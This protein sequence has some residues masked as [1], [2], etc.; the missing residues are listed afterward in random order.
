MGEDLS[1]KEIEKR[2]N[3]CTIIKGNFIFVDNDYDIKLYDENIICNPSNSIFSHVEKN[4]S[5]FQKENELDKLYFSYIISPSHNIFKFNLV[6][7]WGTDE[8]DYPE[9][10]YLN[11]CK[12][13]ITNKN[14]NIL[15]KIQ[16]F[17]E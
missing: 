13:F 7:D 4:W 14:S 16:K 17:Y 12:K 9:F 5:F 10:I 8:Y 11:E 1:C 2:G 6:F 15:N 3:L